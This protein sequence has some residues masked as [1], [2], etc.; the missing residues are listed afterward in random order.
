MDKPH[1]MQLLA[2]FLSFRHSVLQYISGTLED[3][4]CGLC[5]WINSFSSSAMI[6][7][8]TNTWFCQL[9]PK[10]FSNVDLNL[11]YG[12]HNKRFSSRC[13]E[14]TSCVARS[15]PVIFFSFFF[16]DQ[17][18]YTR[19]GRVTKRQ[20]EYTSRIWQK[21]NQLHNEHVEENHYSWSISGSSA[22][23]SHFYSERRTTLEKLHWEFL[24]CVFVCWQACIF[25]SCK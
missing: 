8:T 14:V 4:N 16:L 21:L 12:C 7:F 19:M 20:R 25:V 13:Y 22:F 5:N 23:L 2:S 24:F 18:V 6:L 3:I 17:D 10:N 15:A 11:I 1:Y 9:Q